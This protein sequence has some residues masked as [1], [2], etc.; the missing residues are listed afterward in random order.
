MSYCSLVALSLQI[1]A[2][3]GWVP[4]FSEAAFD[5]VWND[6]CEDLSRVP[7][8]SPDA[9]IVQRAESSPSA[10]Q[11]VCQPPFPCDAQETLVIPKGMTRHTNIL[12]L[13][14][15][16]STDT[17]STSPEHQYF[18]RKLRH[19]RPTALRDSALNN[20]FDTSCTVAA[21]RSSTHIKS[22]IANNISHDT[23]QVART[24]YHRSN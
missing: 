7:H 21:A 5:S 18:Q 8:W 19:Y 23:T 6:G 13:H 2:H 15:Y 20:V 10:L 11:P 16:N 24:R 17:D 22:S 12:P 3:W 1:P 14:V 9:V 4:L